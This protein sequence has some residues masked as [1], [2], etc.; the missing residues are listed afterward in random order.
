MNRLGIDVQTSSVKR[1][2]RRL[3]R[4]KAIESVEDGGAYREEP[5]ASQVLLDTVWT[6]EELDDWLYRTK[7]VD[8]I[9][10]F[11]RSPE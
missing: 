3:K 8:Y 7:G 6:E 1:L 11:A 2:V 4:L 5:N 10:T 9:G